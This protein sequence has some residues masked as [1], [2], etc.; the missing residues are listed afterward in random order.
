VNPDGWFIQEFAAT[1]DQAPRIPEI[2]TGASD[3]KCHHAGR[4]SQPKR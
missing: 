1:T 3:Q 2:A 4:R